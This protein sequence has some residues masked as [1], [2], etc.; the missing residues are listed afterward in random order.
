M[1]RSVAV[2]LLLSSTVNAFAPAVQQRTVTQRWSTPTA[3]QSAK[4][5]TDY[6]TK[7]HEEKL[8]AVKAA[9]QQK[10]GEIEVRECDAALRDGNQQKPLSHHIILYPLL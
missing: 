3:E 4:A 6:M 5:M 10:Q 7:A 8:K 2:A 9:E 1:F